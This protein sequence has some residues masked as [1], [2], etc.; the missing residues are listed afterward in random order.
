MNFFCN[1]F[2]TIFLVYRHGRE[3]IRIASADISRNWLYISLHSMHLVKLKAL[4]SKI[5]ILMI[6]MSQ[7]MQIA[8]YL[9]DSR[10][11]ILNYF[12]HL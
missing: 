3:G 2:W 6:K 12:K 10:E 5:A 8:N 7:F 11:N 9:V 1:I 4:M